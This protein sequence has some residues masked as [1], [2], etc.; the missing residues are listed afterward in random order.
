MLLPEL[1]RQ[2]LRDALPLLIRQVVEL[3][4]WVFIPN[5]ARLLIG[6]LVGVPDLV[7]I[8]EGG[9]VSTSS[10]LLGSLHM[11][12]TDPTAMV[13]HPMVVMVVVAVL[14]AG[15]AVVVG[16]DV[17]APPRVPPLGLEGLV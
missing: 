1:L 2:F 13:I 15:G 12:V 5:Q 3:P 6:S 16:S 17:F 4:S 11:V 14:A 8:P 7:P 10:T 9:M